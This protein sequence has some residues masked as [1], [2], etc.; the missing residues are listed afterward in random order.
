MATRDLQA[1]TTQKKNYLINIIIHFG[2][3]SVWEQCAMA[4]TMLAM[5]VCV[6]ERVN[7]ENMLFS[8]KLLTITIWV[9]LLIFSQSFNLWNVVCIRTCSVKTAVLSFESFSVLD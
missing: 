9:D 6:C 2:W 4:W 7:L 3:Q 1:E 8:A 5:C